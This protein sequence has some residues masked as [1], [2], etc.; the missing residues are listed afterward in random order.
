MATIFR[1][2][3]IVTC[4]TF[5]SRG[6]VLQPPQSGTHSRLAFATFLPQ[7]FVAFF[8]LTASSRPSAP[9]SDSPK[10]LRFG[11]WLTL[12]TQNIHSPTHSLT[13][14][15]ARST[16]M[17]ATYSIFCFQR[18]RKMPEKSQAQTEHK[19]SGSSALYLLQA[20]NN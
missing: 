15:R 1:T 12:C 6:L 20:T 19:L 2:L 14:A 18:S 10:C 5:V 16:I 7:P 4:T 11:H 17:P 8:K 9:P 3:Y 13:P